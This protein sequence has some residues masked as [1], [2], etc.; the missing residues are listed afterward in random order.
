MAT[1]AL[2]AALA[3][4]SIA[5]EKPAAQPVLRRL[6]DFIIETQ[7]RRARQFVAQ[8]ARDR[9]FQLLRDGREPHAGGPFAN[10]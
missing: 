7:S 2:P 1:Q 5:T 10:R 9:G 6:L 8:Y 3:P 4:R